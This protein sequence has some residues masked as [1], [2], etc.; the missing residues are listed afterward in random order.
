PDGDV[1]IIEIGPKTICYVPPMWI[2]RSVN[3][4]AGPLVMS[5]CYPADAGQDYDVIA[6]SNGMKSRIMADGTGWREVLNV[7][8]RTRSA[9]DVAALLASAD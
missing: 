2:H 1:R 9:E 8:Y 6:R 4:G 3:T 7:A 5:F